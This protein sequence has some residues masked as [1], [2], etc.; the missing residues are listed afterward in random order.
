MAYANMK[1]GDAGENVKTLKQLLKGAGFS[2]SDDDV[3]DENTYK[4]VYE[5]QTAN[6]LQADGEA[7]A[8]TWAKLASGVL[9]AMPEGASTKQKVSYLESN[10]PKAYASDYTEKIDD[11]VEH[12]LSREGFS[13]D[14]GED[15]MYQKYKD[16][17]MYLGKRAMN[18]AMGTAAAL[19]G[20]YHNSY[21]QSAG[22]QA[23]QNYLTGLT[24]GMDDMYALALDAYGAETDRLE[25]ALDTLTKR[26]QTAYDRYLD[27]VEEYNRALSY[28]YKKM[29]DEQSSA[30]R[31]SSASASKASRDASGEENALSNILTPSE[32]LKRKTAGASDLAAYATYR[33]Y[34]NA[35][36]KKYA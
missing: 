30:K 9:S 3:Y 13:Y 26:E 17:Y 35:M 27:D 34:S 23:Y 15:P 25:A 14:P 7:G 36:K 22:E 24:D 8:S 29:G 16:R 6:G 31:T 1:I 32:F 20:G 10:R 28:Y 19:S 11:L 33:D 2:T 5:Y 21:A 12:L 4:A 18:D